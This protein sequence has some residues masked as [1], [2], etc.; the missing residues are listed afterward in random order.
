MRSAPGSASRPGFTLIELLV[1]IAIIAILASL[2]LPALAGVKEKA[3][4][5][6]CV[7]NLHQFTVGQLLYA[8][9][10]QNRFANAIRDDGFYAAW[11]ISSRNFT[12]LTE[13][14]G[15]QVLPCPN[16][17]NGV[18]PL[19]PWSNT[20]CPWHEVP[21]GWLIG[22]YVLAGVP[23]TTQRALVS[24]GVATNWVHPSRRLQHQIFLLRPTSTLTC[25][26]RFTLRPPLLRTRASAIAPP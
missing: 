23:E 4:R 14:L 22:Y 13:M 9:D 1:V 17:R 20:T 15:K 11:I 8:A 2:L 24:P 7:S 19:P 21:Y 5:A 6:N 18:A 10:N 26:E 3:R 16:M 25:H 12:N